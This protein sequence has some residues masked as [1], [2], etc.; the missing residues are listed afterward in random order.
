MGYSHS[1]KNMRE[2]ISFKRPR[3]NSVD[4]Q[5]KGLLV[6]CINN[7]LGL[8][9]LFVLIFGQLFVAGCS[10]MLTPDFVQLYGI[11]DSSLR[12]TTGHSFQAPVVIVAGVGG[13]TLT[14]P[15]GREAWFGSISRMVFSNYVDMALEIDADTLQPKPSSLQATRLPATVLGRD[16]FGSLFEVL[17]KYGRYKHTKPGTPYTQ[18]ERRYYTFAYDWRY[19]NI[20]TVHKLDAFIEQI[21][22]DY[23][24]PDLKVDIVAH[25][26][27]GLIVR[28]YMRYGT[29]DLLD[30]NDF[31]VTQIGAGKVRRFIQLGTPNMGSVSVLHQLIRG[32]KPM[33][34]IV[35]PEVLATMPSTYQLLPHPL[36]QWLV[37]A[38]GEPLQ[39]D[40]FDADTWRHFQWGVYDPEVIARVRSRYKNEAEGQKQIELLQRY[41]AKH[42]ERAR[43]F[44]WSLSVRFDNPQ[45]SIISFGG[46]CT[47]T[48]AR[49]VV[50]EIEGISHVRLTPEEIVN[51]LQGIDYEHLMLEPGDGSV[52]KP[53]MLARDFL[54]PAVA[55]HKYSFI[56]LAYTFFLCH[57]HGQ[58]AGNVNF[59][60]NLLN[61]LLEKTQ[62]EAQ[63]KTSG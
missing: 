51:P 10:S 63:T 50:E 38:A 59:Q 45:Y 1:L 60:D 31:P 28:Y 18:Q 12:S 24:M 37:T 40:L 26:M 55:R 9:R 49:I 39:R 22:S 48:P 36:N 57:N 25:S 46:N 34:R 4:C 47:L 6:L 35:P 21:R 54:D 5:Q 56:P 43:R 17:E 2:F 15:S 16:F 3:F 33:L 29:V 14:D 19:D 42:I 52:T 23:D 62:D 11:D 32:Y 44:V 27:G 53:S 61:I 20:D 30:G 13:S 7:P 58:L 41:F 8:L